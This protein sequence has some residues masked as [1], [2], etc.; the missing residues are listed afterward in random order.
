MNAVPRRK[1]SFSVVF[2]WISTNRFH[3]ILA[4]HRQIQLA[5]TTY[6]VYD[7]DEI[8]PVLHANEVEAQSGVA[9]LHCGEYAGSG[10][11]DE[12]SVE[13][14]ALGPDRRQR[15]KCRSSQGHN[16]GGEGGGLRVGRPA[17]HSNQK[18]DEL[19]KGNGLKRDG[20]LKKMVT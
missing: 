12:G 4:T 15:E 13:R 18:K 17:F 16:D 7:E 2:F 11:R 19:D 8:A 3:C 1:V 10:K 6:P 9:Q 20:V 14:Q 5:A